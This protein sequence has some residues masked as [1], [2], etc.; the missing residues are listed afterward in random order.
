MATS[1]QP[2]SNFSTF[3][4]IGLCF[5]PA[6]LIVPW[7]NFSLWLEWYAI[8][9]MLYRHFPAFKSRKGHLHFVEL[10]A[11]QIK[12]VELRSKW[13][14]L[15]MEWVGCLIESFLTEISVMKHVWMREYSLIVLSYYKIADL[16]WFSHFHWIQ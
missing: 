3:S 9:K 15:I 5:I 2:F 10:M 12:F 6:R 8:T 16:L 14:C 7:S 11:C 4:L 1:L 13:S